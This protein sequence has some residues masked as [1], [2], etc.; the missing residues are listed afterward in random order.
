MV[1]HMAGWHDHFMAHEWNIK[2]FSLDLCIY[3]TCVYWSVFMARCYEVA[4]VM[5]STWVHI[6]VHLQNLSHSCLT[7][8][9]QCMSVGFVRLSP[10]ENHITAKQEFMAFQHVLC[11]SIALVRV[12]LNIYSIWFTM[13]TQTCI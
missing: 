8:Q 12:R 4:K 6:T 10:E 5:L 3:H 13:N 7:S 9:L 2:H 1:N 11:C